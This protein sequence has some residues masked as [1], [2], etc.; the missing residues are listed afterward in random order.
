MQNFETRLKEERK[1]LGLKGGQLAQIGGVSAVSQS[2]YEKGKQLPGAAYLAAIAAVGVDVQYVLTGQRSAE[3]VLTPEEKVVLAAWKK[4]SK[5]VQAAALA[6]L[7]AGADA[8]KPARQIVGGDV[9][10]EPGGKTII[11]E[12]IGSLKM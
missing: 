5:E 1:R 9:H 3:P 10:T 6:A 12:N 7:Q 4:A 2:S 11:A 8:K